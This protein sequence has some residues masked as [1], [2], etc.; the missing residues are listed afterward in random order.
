M[1][2][3][4]TI[5]TT[6]G[7]EQLLL[8]AYYTGGVGSASAIQS[9]D[10]YSNLDHPQPLLL[11]PQGGN[12]GIGTITPSY[13]LD[14]SGN[15]RASN[16][17]TLTNGSNNSTIYQQNSSLSIQNNSN[18]YIYI[19]AVGQNGIIVYNNGYVGI[20]GEIAAAVP[21]SA[22]QVNGTVTA[23]SY[24]ATS[25]YRIKE[26]VVPLNETFTVDNLRPVTYNNIKNGK[27][28]I[29]LIAHE[30]QEVYPFLVNGEKDGENFQSVNYTGLIGILIKEIQELKK[31]VKML[32]EKL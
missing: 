29:G 31:E 22:L 6:T 21:V 8:G 27:Q 20:G 3:A 26:N 24:D 23:T 32:K 13:T 1:P 18:G 17:L 7:S 28:D 25:D 11:N 2:A 16:T 14:V 19:N 12:V 4:L 9:V 15:I 30:L 5:A 10:Y